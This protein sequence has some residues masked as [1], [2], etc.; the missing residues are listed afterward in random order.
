MATQ[1]EGWYQEE[2]KPA[3]AL[4]AGDTVV[5][6]KDIK[7]W[8][9]AVKDQAFSHIAITAGSPEWLEAVSEEQYSQLN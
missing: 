7:H 4:K 1:G 2:G 5:T 8:H 6:Y 3:R 9:G